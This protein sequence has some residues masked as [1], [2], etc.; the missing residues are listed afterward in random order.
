MNRLFRGLLAIAV[1]AAFLVVAPGCKDEGKPNPDLQVP[2][3]KPGGH[4]AKD[5]A[6][7]AK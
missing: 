5:A 7:K 6:K 4:G 2:D 1:G 3:V